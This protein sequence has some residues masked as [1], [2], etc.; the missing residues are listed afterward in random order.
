M[1]IFQLRVSIIGIPRLYRLIDISG[2]C[3]FED[4]HDMIFKVFDRYDPHLYSFFLTR[5]DSKSFRTIYDSPEITHP[6]NVEDIMGYGR[7]RR[8][9]AETRIG[10]IELNEKDVFHYLFDFGD[11][12]WH[13]IRVQKIGRVRTTKKHMKL[14]KSAGS[15]PDQYPDYD[16]DYD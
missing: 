1:K 7:K 13:R 15:S 12:W 3:S 16:E 4:L 8:S 14:I 5:E 6:Q 10:D 2:N 9:A 11:D